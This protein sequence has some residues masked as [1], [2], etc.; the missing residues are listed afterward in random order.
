[1]FITGKYEILG[2]VLGRVFGLALQALGSHRS[3]VLVV[4]GL[5]ASV[6]RGGSLSYQ[7][8]GIRV[9]SGDNTCAYLGQRGIKGQWRNLREI[10]SL[11]A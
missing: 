10:G 5:E 7:R 4:P 8:L 3:V 9:V 2:L 6:I 1:M 11:F